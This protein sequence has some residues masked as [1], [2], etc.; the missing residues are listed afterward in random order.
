VGGGFGLRSS[1]RRPHLPRQ[2]EDTR[3]RDRRDEGT[4]TSV[5]RRWY[6]AAVAGLVLWAGAWLYV[7]IR[8]ANEVYGLQEL[9]S[10]VVDVGAA[11]RASGE[12]L[13]SLSSVPVV[14]DQLEEPAGRIVRAGDSAVA[15]GRA[16]RESVRDL[17]VLLGITISI[18]PTVPMLA[19]LLVLRRERLRRDRTSPV[20]RRTA[21]TPGST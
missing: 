6:M 15:S 10:T 17:A 13:R 1:G 5:R 11:V 7:G 18:V 9:S 3:H 2:P 16:S 4:S 12:T 20:P 19:V 21:A 8:T 14:G